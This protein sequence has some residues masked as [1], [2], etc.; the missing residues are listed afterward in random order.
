MPMTRYLAGSDSLSRVEYGQADREHLNMSSSDM[1]IASA[2]S[3]Q[4]LALE[5]TP[6]LPPFG[7]SARSVLVIPSHLHVRVR[8]GKQVNISPGSSCATM[9]FTTG[10][11]DRKPNH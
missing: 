6:A 10:N 1:G 5:E 8:T 3:W 9:T 4:L 2:N 11:P 7:L